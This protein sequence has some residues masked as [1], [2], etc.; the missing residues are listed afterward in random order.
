MGMSAAAGGDD[1]SSLQLEDL[2]KAASGLM[3]T[4]RL[5][6]AELSDMVRAAIDSLPDQ[7]RMALLLSKF[8]EMS[9]VDVA[10][11]L[12]L[13]VPSVK[14]LLWRAREN[15]RVILEPYLRDGARP[16]TGT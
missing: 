7:Q 8:E 9:Y 13:T 15:L 16:E 2:A 4:R 10:R 12:D 3:P 1:S 11:T 6:K 14:S 5:D